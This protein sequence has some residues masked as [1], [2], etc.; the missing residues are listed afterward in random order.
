MY[1]VR[2]YIPLYGL[3]LTL[4]H[5]ALTSQAQD[6]NQQ[7]RDSLEVELLRTTQTYDQV[8]QLV[9]ILPAESTYLSLIPSVL[10]VNL[11]I[12]AFRIVSPFGMRQ[13]PLLKKSK[14]H[15]GV[16]VKATIGIPVKATAAGVVSQVGFDTALGAFVRLKHAFGFETVYGHLKGY[17]VKPG[18][19][20]ELNE[21]IGR[22]GQTGMTTGP[23]LHYV[24]KK[25]GSAID[26]FQFC[27]LLRH[28]L[29]LYQSARPTASGISD[30]TGVECPSDKGI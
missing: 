7:K 8:V 10:P 29:W 6:I 21:E 14:F 16:D 30:S 25:N 15:G 12:D 4:G 24:I 3:I 23:H 5:F 18:Q 26:P 20:I 9:H 27:F 28:R 22:V 11:P 13:H 17:C 1:V 19:Q 2:N